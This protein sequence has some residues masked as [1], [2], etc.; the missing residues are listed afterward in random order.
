MTGSNES[1]QPSLGGIVL[2]LHP[3][4]FDLH[5]N[6]I[7]QDPEEE[8]VHQLSF[9]KYEVGSSWSVAIR[10]NLP[11][12]QLQTAFCFWSNCWLKRT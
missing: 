10:L 11:A 2:D 4:Q 6:E 7:L 3:E 1:P 5:C 9:E 8:Q 12:Q